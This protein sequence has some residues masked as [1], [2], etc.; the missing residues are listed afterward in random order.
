VI[1]QPEVEQPD[2]GQALHERRR[3]RAGDAAWELR[4]AVPAVL[5]DAEPADLCGELRAAAREQD[6]GGSRRAVAQAEVLRGA[7]E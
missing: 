6:V 7:R 5:L 3:L 1:G 2:P 4:R